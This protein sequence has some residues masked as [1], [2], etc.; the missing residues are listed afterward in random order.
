MLFAFDQHQLSEHNLFGGDFTLFDDL[1]F[2]KSLFDN[3]GTTPNSH[4]SASFNSTPSTASF[5]IST[6]DYHCIVSTLFDENPSTF[7]LPTVP[8][9]SPVPSAFP[10]K[11]TTPQTPQQLSTPSTSG[12]EDPSPGCEVISFQKQI[13][14]FGCISPPGLASSPQLS[15]S[16][17]NGP[18]S[19]LVLPSAPISENFPKSFFPPLGTTSS[20]ASPTVSSAFSS[21]V[22][23]NHKKR[24]ATAE[25]TS[26]RP[27]EIVD[28]AIQSDDDDRNV[29][30]KRNTAAARR[31]RQKKQ[32]KM[33]ELEEILEGMTK[34]R[35][36][37]RDE[38]HRQRMEAEKWH[39]MV[40]F[41]EKNIRK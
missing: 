2:E 1:E 27:K 34:D 33:K 32:D 38:A 22:N 24:K 21:S 25:S 14:E 13:N 3:P 7:S 16:S 6:A 36:R 26:P 31:Y 18:H 23:I 19:R 20:S 17:P 30:R 35:D 9:P 5:D 29:K 40:E 12:S 28:T 11:A 8:D 41:M 4:S 37:W 10:I 15:S 39:A